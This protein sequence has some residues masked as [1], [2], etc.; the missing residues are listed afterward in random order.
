MSERA[1]YAPRHHRPCPCSLAC[2]QIRKKS[3]FDF[4]PIISLHFEQKPNRQAAAKL[5]AQGGL[6]CVATMQGTS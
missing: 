3:I 5:K 6:R 2:S 1:N 4:Y